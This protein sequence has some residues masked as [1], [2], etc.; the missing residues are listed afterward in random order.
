MQQLSG[1]QGKVIT[2]SLLIINYKSRTIWIR[3][4]IKRPTLAQIIN[5]SN[6]PHLEQQ[7]LTSRKWGSDAEKCSKC[8]NW[9]NNSTI[10][11]H[12]SVD[13]HQGAQ[14]HLEVRAAWASH[15]KYYFYSMDVI[16]L[17]ASNCFARDLGGLVLRLSFAFRVGGKRWPRSQASHTDTCLPH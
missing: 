9:P 12:H 1:K 6:H 4:S 2:D 5:L 10:S 16:W 17:T 8:I 15:R 7:H 11:S 14:C 3:L 13:S